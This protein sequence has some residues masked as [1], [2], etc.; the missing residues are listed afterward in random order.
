MAMLRS[1]LT[2][3]LRCQC[4]VA[5][6]T[7]PTSRLAPPVLQLCSNIQQFENKRDFSSLQSNLRH[8]TVNGI[9]LGCIRSYADLPDLTLDQVKERVLYV[10]KLYDKINPEKLILTSHFMNDL[11][12]DSLD[13]VEVIMAMEDEFGFEIPD[14]HA[15]KLMTPK[16]IVEYIA[17]RQD[18]FE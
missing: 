12:L 10:L 7:R 14:S 1:A 16:D 2:R 13:Q 8:P 18:V 3:A 11:G 6:A 15:E 5:V 9:T 17:D 4:A